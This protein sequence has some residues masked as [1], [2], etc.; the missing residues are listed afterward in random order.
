MTEATR[1]PARAPR[2][3]LV[4]PA[5]LFATAVAR[6]PQR[7]LLAT[8]GVVHALA[9]PLL[10]SRRR[11][12]QRNIAL[13]FRDLDPPAQAALVDASLRNAVI[14]LLE[15]LRGWF[16]RDA[17]LRALVTV[18][19]LEHLRAA[20]AGGRGAL[21][22]TGHLNHTELGARMLALA[23]REPVTIVA[24]RNNRSC[25]ERFLHAA[26]MRVFANVV[27]KKDARGLMRALVGGETVVWA[28]DQDFNYRSQFVPFFGVPAATI[29]VM[30]HL[31][32]RADAAV[33]P[34]A[35]QRESDGRYR[36]RIEPAWE[37]LPEAQDAVRY[38]AWLEGVVR[39][40]PAQYLW[41]HRRF[42]TRPPG[43]PDLYARDA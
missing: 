13:C 18:E 41:I 1:S 8:A 32:R 6:L 40:H 16:G 20:R 15:L 12:A 39:R 21:L 10:R 5:N 19:G 17:D 31:G 28:G 36:L 14:G 35:M 43:E 26:R 34:Y 42:K 7:A 24:R 9:G 33:V 30:S 11:I 2:C 27:D 37:P 29:S 4:G 38:M 22:V 23:L 25:M 3:W